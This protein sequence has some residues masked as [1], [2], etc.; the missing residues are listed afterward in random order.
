ML[1]SLQ[2]EHDVEALK[3][4]AADFN[5]GKISKQYL[6]VIFPEDV[7]PEMEIRS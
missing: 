7:F 6:E 5:V 3:A 1:E 4:R 2:E